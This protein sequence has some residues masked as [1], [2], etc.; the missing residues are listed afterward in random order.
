LTE[1]LQDRKIEA[2]VTGIQQG[3]VKSEIRE[4]VAELDICHEKAQKAQEEL[5]SG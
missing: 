1:E 3:R 4:M 2:I 5:L